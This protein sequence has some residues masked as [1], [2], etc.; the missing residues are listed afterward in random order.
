MLDG[1]KEAKEGI[2]GSKR[3]KEKARKAVKGQM[4][5]KGKQ[6]RRRRTIKKRVRWQ[7]GNEM[8]ALHKA[9]E[10]E[11]N[12]RQR[13]NS[14]S[15]SGVERISEREGELHKQIGLKQRA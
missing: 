6:R 2:S 13:T 10:S 12:F 15:F 8:E 7:K 9:E 11:T 1:R 5:E 14:L 4:C 3:C